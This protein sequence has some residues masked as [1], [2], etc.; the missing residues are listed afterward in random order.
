ML[1]TAAVLTAAVAATC[2][3]D[4][5]S[6]IS[7]KSSSFTPASHVMDDEWTNGN[8][9]CTVL[10]HGDYHR[11]VVYKHHAPAFTN[12]KSEMLY[13]I[14]NGTFNGYANFTEYY[15]VGVGETFNNQTTKVADGGW[16]STAPAQ[17]SLTQITVDGTLPTK[18][19]SISLTANDGTEIWKGRWLERSG[20]DAFP[21]AW[22][23]PNKVMSTKLK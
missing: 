23:H 19:M 14:H 7:V 10:L 21:A 8:K 16:A 3:A 15:G 2:R 1:A 17:W 18:E 11:A 6:T 9:G 4:N 5:G 20:N 12:N 13:S 22:E